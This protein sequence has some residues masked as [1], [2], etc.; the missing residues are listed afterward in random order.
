MK[1]FI[2]LGIVLLCTLSSFAQNNRGKAE[3][4][5]QITDRGHY[6]VYLDDEFMG[7]SKGR[8]R[9]YD[10]YN[11]SPTLTIL[12]GNKKIFSRVLEV[13]PSTRLILSY[14]SR[15]GLSIINELNLYR[16][17]VYALNDFDGYIEPYNTG[18]VPPRYPTGNNEIH[19]F[20]SLSSAVKK[21]AFDDTKMKL[22][23]AYLAYGEIS[24]T[25]LITLLNHFNNDGNKLT[26][27]KSAYPNITDLGNYYLVR[28]AF[29]FS[30]Y[31]EEFT[32]FAGAQKT[33]RHLRP[34]SPEDFRQF[35]TRMSSEAFDDNK[36]TLAKTVIPN[37]LLTTEQLK[38]L[39]KLYSFEDKALIFAK[40][41][42]PNASDKANYFTIADV[43][44]F[45]SNRKDL[46]DFLASQK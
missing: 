34:I 33:N 35:Y 30:S 6:T 5:I 24:S 2:L 41:A 29:T 32:K 10:V 4:F 8:F 26:L 18:I 13:N 43:L 3:V 17:R 36:T 45:P 28:D 22:I 14:N 42:F 19:Q 46:L 27:A 40:L 20:E 9:F 15:R 12:S 25:Q 38:S 7:S 31:K 44:K 23:E 39:I 21:E 16:N 11:Y 1:K 37:V